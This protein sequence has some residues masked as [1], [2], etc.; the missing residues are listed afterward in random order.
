MRGSPGWGSTW[1]MPRPVITSPQR[2]SARRLS[3]IHPRARPSRHAAYRVDE[4][5]LRLE[6][7]SSGPGQGVAEA[8][9]DAS[10]GSESTV[11]R[12]GLDTAAG[13]H[14]AIDEG[15]ADVDLARGGAA[16]PA[17]RARLLERGAPL[18]L[19]PNSAQ[20]GENVDAM[21]RR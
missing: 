2:K 9:R 19:A 17:L 1:S 15:G 21:D 3:V 20:V 12:D 4:I 16:E 6:N 14:D 10:H 18:A 13:R 5:D 11:L 8:G 7:L